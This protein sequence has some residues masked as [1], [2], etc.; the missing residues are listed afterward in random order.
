VADRDLLPAVFVL[1]LRL[2]EEPDVDTNKLRDDELVKELLGRKK[3]L[4]DRGI[5]LTVVLIASR[6][7]L[8]QSLMTRRGVSAGCS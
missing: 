4:S 8:G 3:A 6:E 1:F 5:K 7:L 2:S